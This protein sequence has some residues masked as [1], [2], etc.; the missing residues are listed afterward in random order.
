M[1]KFIRHPSDVP[2]EIL[3]GHTDR[4][5][6]NQLNNVG[7]GGLSCKS[8][9]FMESGILIRVR[10]P[11]VRPAFETEGQVVWCKKQNGN[12]DIG[13]EFTESKKAFAVRMV[14]Q[15]CHI[16]HYKKEIFKTEGRKLNGNEAASEWIG[17]YASEFPNP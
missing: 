5:E 6:S 1:R 10:I 4:Q 3:A 15:I 11:L 17:R 2:I 8:D 12:F 9:V 7:F 13:I 14:E 16:E